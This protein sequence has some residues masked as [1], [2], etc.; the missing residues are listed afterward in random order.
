MTG[1]SEERAVRM[2]RCRPRLVSRVPIAAAGRSVV[3]RT[4]GRGRDRRVHA[5]IVNSESAV[6]VTVYRVVGG[7]SDDA[8]SSARSGRDLL[9]GAFKTVNLPRPEEKRGAGGVATPGA[10]VRERASWV[11]SSH[12]CE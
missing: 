8:A 6:A 9:Q 5:R 10:G 3:R 7:V 11:L 4:G 2:Q 1:L 12:L